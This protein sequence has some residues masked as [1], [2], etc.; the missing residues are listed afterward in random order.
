LPIGLQYSSSYSGNLSGTFYFWVFAEFDFSYLLSP[1][2]ANLWWQSTN[3]LWFFINLD[4]KSA[5]SAS[6]KNEYN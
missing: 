4:P 3:R 1:F 5:I 2:S 6:I